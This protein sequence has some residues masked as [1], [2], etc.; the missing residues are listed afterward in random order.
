MIDPGPYLSPHIFNILVRLRHGK[1]GIDADIKK[2]FPQ[3][4]I[5]DDQHEF[6]QM[7]WY[8]NIF[9]QNPTM[10]ILRF[11][12]EIFGRRQTLLF[13]TP[14]VTK[15]FTSQTYR[16]NYSKTNWRFIFR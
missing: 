8:E 13:S 12:R 3:I 5:D 6:L 1:I 15:K 7:I 9:A 16:R 4:A 10:K 14:T 11:E 2:A